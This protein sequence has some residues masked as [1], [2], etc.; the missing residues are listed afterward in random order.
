MSK[1]VIDEIR[2]LVK[3]CTDIPVDDMIASGSWGRITFEAAKVDLETMFS[4]LGPLEDYPLHVLPPAQLNAMKAVLEPIDAVL[5]EIKTF[6]I[7]TGNPSELRDDISNRLKGLLHQAHTPIAMELPFLA[8]QHGDVQKNLNQLSSSIESAKAM[9]DKGQSDLNA[10]TKELEDIIVAARE[11]SAEVGVAHFTTD[12]SDEALGFARSAKAWLW[13]SGVIAAGAAGFSFYFI[14][15]KPAVGTSIAEVIQF[16][17]A[18]LI[19]LSILI[20]AATW[21]GGQF[22]SAKHQQS[23]N[24]H[25]SN[26]LKTFRAFSQAASDDRARDA[27]L[28][29]TTRAIFGHV[30]SGYMKDTSGGSDGSVRIVEMIRDGISAPDVD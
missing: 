19:F 17:A 1:E 2:E 29:E 7:E 22:R 5:H 28:M 6:S 4:L 13:A 27:V 20:A 26:S 12:F 15:W 16:S 18:K 11:A 14:F 21:C 8:Y 10:K 9:L 3:S 24:K 25:R 23:T 30:P